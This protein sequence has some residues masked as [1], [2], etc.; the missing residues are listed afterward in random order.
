MGYLRSRMG[1]CRLR[2]NLLPP[3]A[4]GGLYGSGCFHFESSSSVC[5]TRSWEEKEWVSGESRNR[6]AIDLG[7]S[8]SSSSRPRAC[9]P[10]LSNLFYPPKFM[11]QTTVKTGGSKSTYP[12]LSGL[13][14]VLVGFKERADV[15]S[16]TAPKVSVDGPVKGELQR[17]AVETARES[18]SGGGASRRIECV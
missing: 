4:V 12:L 8:S 14:D 18:V 16:L 10:P 7:V 6:F 11:M 15:K 17:A 2:S 13:L 9:H 5:W 1:H 3:G